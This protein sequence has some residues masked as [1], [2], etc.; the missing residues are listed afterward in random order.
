MHVSGP[1]DQEHC[2]PPGTAVIVYAET[3][4][5]PSLAGAVHETT[6]CRMPAVPVTDVGTPGVVLGVRV[7]DGVEDG[8]VPSEFSA[9]TTNV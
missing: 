5:P 2:L 9:V 3:L 4:E 1:L 8:L 6:A 7:W